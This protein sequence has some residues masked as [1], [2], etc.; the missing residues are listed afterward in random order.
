MITWLFRKFWNA[1]PSFRP[2]ETQWNMEEEADAW[3]LLTEEMRNI[4]ETLTELV[5]VLR[6]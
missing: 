3:Y 4:N 5:E 2:G 6:K 1:G